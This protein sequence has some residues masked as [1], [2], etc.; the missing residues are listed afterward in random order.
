MSDVAQ[1]ALV[2]FLV[3]VNAVFAGSEMAL[4]SL[5]PAQ[6]ERL[7]SRGGAGRAVASLTGDPNR[8]LAT[9]QIAITLSGFMAS[10]T[11][12]V[13][14]AEP[15]VPAL[16]FLGGWAEGVAVV[17]VTLILTFFTL[18]FG[19]LAP[20]RIAMQHAEGWALAVARPLDVIAAVSRPVVWLL[21][22]STDLVVRIAG[23]DPSRQR[24]EVTEDEIRDMVAAQVSL[25]AEEKQVITGAL[26]VSERSLRQ[27]LV[28]RQAVFALPADLTIEAAVPLVLAS[29]HSRV[30]VYR[31]EPDRMMGV[32][33]LRQL[34]APDAPAGGILEEVAA[35]LPAFPE[36]APVLATLRQ[37]QRDHQQMALVVDEHGGV[38]GIV[39][40]ED[41]V[42]EIV[43]EI[44][45][46]YDRDIALV[47]RHP[48]GSLE[49]AGSF[50]FHDLV[51]LGIEAPEGPYRTVAGL[52][53]DRLGRMSAVGD[54]IALDG[55]E[56]RV[57][58][59]SPTAITRVLAVPIPGIDEG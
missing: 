8:F 33:Q 26:E 39:T 38:E 44:Y 15:L 17:L 3:V 19:E 2:A 31:G 32:V 46:E 40:I 16:E 34:I 12:A 30:P 1:L 24:E 50:P 23:S 36:S 57:T 18:V 25:T 59:V 14:L 47:V 41:L 20:K 49:L 54:A 48:D 43:G 10:A 13:S 28:P 9:I 6:V 7:R 27:V 35:A 37:L 52:I 4:V 21:S 42:E 53:L 29:G 11:A 22:A 45:D 5:R 55:W 58:E 51:D 56:L